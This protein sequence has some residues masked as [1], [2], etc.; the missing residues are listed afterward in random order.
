MNQVSI[1]YDLYERI[2]EAQQGDYGVKRILE[3]IL[4]GETQGFT[5]DKGMLKIGHRVCEPQDARLKEKIMI[6]AHHTPY[7]VH[8]G[9]TKMYQDLRT[10]FWWEGMNKDIALSLI[11]I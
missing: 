9:A 11:H 5:C 3:K 10:N 1:Q 7:M 4:D 8:P 6:E 2:K